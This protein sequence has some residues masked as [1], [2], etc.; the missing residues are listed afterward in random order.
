MA[1]VRP[2]KDKLLQHFM[3]QLQDEFLAA[4]NPSDEERVTNEAVAERIRDLLADTSDPTWE[5]AYQVQRLL[6]FIR[7]RNKLGI[8]TDRR[9]SEAEGVGL[10]AS[11]KYRAQFAAID[12]REK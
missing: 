5:R 9:I 8:E 4:Q 7:P 10:P 2:R 1:W 11:A 12:Q 3:F 6:V